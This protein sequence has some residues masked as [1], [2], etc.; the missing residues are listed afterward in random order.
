MPSSV[1]TGVRSQGLS[2][3]VAHGLNI[4]DEGIVAPT[5]MKA[6]ITHAPHKYRDIATTV[7][8]ADA[9]TSCA[10]NTAMAMLGQ[11]RISRCRAINLDPIKYLLYDTKEKVMR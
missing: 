1:M 2:R 8:V 10:L 11:S 7:S 6:G 3:S 4:T 9:L 5:E